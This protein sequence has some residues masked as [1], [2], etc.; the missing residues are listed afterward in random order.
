M[1]VLGLLWAAVPGPWTLADQ[2]ELAP[3][4]AAFRLDQGAGPDLGAGVEA[5]ARCGECHQEAYQ[6]WRNSR[7]AVAG[8]NPLFVAGL[9]AEPS[10]RCLR[11]HA[12]RPEEAAPFRAFLRARRQDPRA[13]LQVSE[14]HQGV[15]CSVCHVRD[16]VVLTGRPVSTLE[17]PTRVEPLL[18]DA[19]FCAGCHQF[20]FERSDHV[21]QDTYREW[22]R[23]GAK[24]CLDCH[25]AHQFPGAHD[26]STLAQ[27]VRVT[28]RREGSRVILEVEASDGLG[29]HLPTGD[30]F[31]ALHLEV[32]RGE[33]VEPVATFG[34]TFVVEREG[35]GGPLQKRIADDTSLRPGERRRFVVDGP[36]E[37]WRLSY[38]YAPAR[39]VARGLPPEWVERTLATG[40]IGA[41]ELNP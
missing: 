23:S 40:T 12:P 20:N 27:A 8:S 36:I 33:A 25:P 11:C 24:P 4:R 16:G 2:E 5:S 22:K 7:H 31:R 30:L 35:E 3:V 17:H 19:R 18:K 28:A 15:A 1:I 10:P 37:A 6:G 21:T 39:A 26:P 13:T 29:H 32:R 41:G 34:R 9:E 38:R 14:A